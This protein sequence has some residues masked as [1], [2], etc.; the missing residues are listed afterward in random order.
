MTAL[1]VLTEARRLIVEEGWT[2]GQMEKNGRYCAVGAVLFAKR[3]DPKAPRVYP[4]IYE[5]IGRTSEAELVGWNDAQ[6][7]K[8]PVVAAFDRAI[9]LAKERGL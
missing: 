1:A 4:L 7:S 8:K 9:L 3:D 6:P 5:A 2:R